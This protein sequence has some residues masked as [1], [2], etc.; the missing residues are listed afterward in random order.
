MLLNKIYSYFYYKLTILVQLPRLIKYKLLSNCKVIGKPNLLQPLQALGKGTICFNGK[1]I[2]GI[3]PSPFFFN[4]YAYIEAKNPGSSVI[5]GN[6]TFINN[7]F[8]ACSE[9]KSITIGENVLIGT[10]V[11]I[12]DSNFHGIDP[13]QRHLSCAESASDVVIENNVFIGS[14]VKILKGVTIGRDSVIAN[15]SIVTKN[16]PPR[17]VAGGNPA[18]VLKAI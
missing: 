13:D 10:C 5:I 16:I 3:F 14:H 7:N 6:G 4:G 15:G 17:V 12:I 2:I 18:R 8:V 9:Y 1:V 11:E